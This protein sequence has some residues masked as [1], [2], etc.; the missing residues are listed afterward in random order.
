MDDHYLGLRRPWEVFEIYEPGCEFLREKEAL[1]LLASKGHEEARLEIVRQY[2]VH[3]R[4]LDERSEGL[5]W[6]V[7]PLFG[8][9]PSVLPIATSA[10][11]PPF[12]DRPAVSIALHNYQRA[13][14]WFKSL[15]VS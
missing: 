13:E 8:I 12:D 14:D 11:L 7:M 1:L 15:G 2:L 3:R 4:V 5:A 9:V 10:E 6:W